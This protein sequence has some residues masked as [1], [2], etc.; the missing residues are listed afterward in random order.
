MKKII[1]ILFYLPIILSAQDSLMIQIEMDRLETTQTKISENPGTFVN[2]QDFWRIKFN[3]SNNFVSVMECRKEFEDQF[4]KLHTKYIGN[5]S[6]FITQAWI[7]WEYLQIMSETLFTR[8]P[9]KRG[10]MN[11]DE[12]HAIWKMHEKERAYV[13]EKFI[14]A[15]EKIPENKRDDNLN[16]F[17]KGMLK[18]ISLRKFQRDIKEKP[19]PDFEYKT[20]KGETNKLSNLRGHYIILH[21]WQTDCNPCIYDIANMHQVFNLYEPKGLKI[22]SINASSLDSQWDIDVLKNVIKELDMTWIQVPDGK[23][24][25]IHELYYI[26]IWPTSFLINKEGYAIKFDHNLRAEKLLPT[27]KSIFEEH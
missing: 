19:A 22:I 17:Y 23:N 25:R 1:L 14:Q 11:R 15:V 7:Y 26:S 3:L 27:L 6:L 9:S 2:Y 5:D 18:R 12:F 24:K 4:E 13:N 8:L 20:L 21:F 16:K 10:Q